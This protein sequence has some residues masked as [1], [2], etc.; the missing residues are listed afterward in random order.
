ML[1]MIYYPGFEVRDENWLK[2]A[3]LYIDKI[4]P[5]I[6]YGAD[7]YLSSSFRDIIEKTNL[8]SPHIPKYEEGI[9]ASILAVEQFE[10]YLSHPEIYV[11]TFGFSKRYGHDLSEKWRNKENQTYTLFQD[12]FSGEFENFCLRERIAQQNHEGLKISEDL[13]FVY[14]SLFA[15]NISRQNNLDSITDV[16]KYSKILLETDRYDSNRNNVEMIT[17]KREIELLIPQKLKQ[18][19]LSEFIKLRSNPDF[20][21]QRKAFSRLVYQALN[22]NEDKNIHSKLVEYMSYKKEY[23]ELLRCSFDILA[24]ITMTAFSTYSLLDNNISNTEKINVIASGYA[25]VHLGIDVINRIPK[26]VKGL[27]KKY[28]A[29]KYVASIKRITRREG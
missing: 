21:S 13:A 7:R 26:T 20:E 22:A 3:L 4:R 9:S 17:A 25:N 29:K 12:K 24:A 27:K 18:I 1:D 15:N 28:F 19:P 2:F 8:V 5:I 23:V 14:M 10:R 16:K 6:P 11:T